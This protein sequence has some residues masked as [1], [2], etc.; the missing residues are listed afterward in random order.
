MLG[1]AEMLTR[2]SILPGEFEARRILASQEGLALSFRAEGSRKISQ[3]A[4]Q[5]AFQLP[6]A[7]TTPRD[8]SMSG[9]HNVASKRSDIIGDV[10]IAESRHLRV[11]II[12]ASLVPR[13][14]ED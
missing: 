13:G 7:E 4:T 6:V 9:P 11:P 8:E 2:R 12:A 3:R 10:W 14:R 1:E 5:P